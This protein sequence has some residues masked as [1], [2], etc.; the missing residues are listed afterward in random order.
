MIDPGDQDD[1]KT[2]N[3]GKYGWTSMPERR[4]KLGGVTNFMG[5]GNLNFNYQ[6]SNCNGEY[7]IAKGLQP[8]VRISFCHNLQ[9]LVQNQSKAK[10][11][12]RLPLTVLRRWLRAIRFPQVQTNVGKLNQKSIGR[13][14]Q[15]GHF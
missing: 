4:P 5:R 1:R 12:L 7:T 11:G 3:K 2:K 9:L 8:R 6:K 13:A 10:V 14:E 15:H